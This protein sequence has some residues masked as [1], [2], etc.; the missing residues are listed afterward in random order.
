MALV[1]R[2]HMTSGSLLLR[3]KGL[4]GYLV[5][6]AL[7]PQ[8]LGIHTHVLCGLAFLRREEQ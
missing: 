5:I 7:G 4:Q 6:V 3:H 1:R 8:Q 2:D